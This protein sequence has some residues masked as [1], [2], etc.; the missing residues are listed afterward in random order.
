M[1]VF[2]VYH[3][4]LVKKWKELVIKQLARLE[5]S[6]LLARA[7]KLY[8]VVIDQNNNKQEFLDIISK[9][10]NIEAEFFK[11]N[12]CEFQSITKVWQLGQYNDCK[13]LYFHTKGVFN[14]YV[15]V[16]GTEISDLKVKTVRDWRMLMEYFCID[17]WDENL[18]RLDS[19]D[20]VGTNCTRNWWWGNFWWARSSYL[21][22]LEL[23]TKSSRWGYEAWVNERGLAS[24]YEHH[25]I[26]FIFYF[27]DYP[28]K[29]YKDDQYKVLKGSTITVHEA[30]YGASEIQIDEGYAK[31]APVFKDVTDI[32]RANLAKNN[33]LYIDIEVNNDTMQ[34]DP[35]FMTKKSIFIEYSFDKEPDKKYSLHSIE[36]TPI[37][38]PWFNL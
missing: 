15:S 23:P 14:D 20:M 11:D 2:I 16:D 36:H 35:I 33:N 5:S 18:Q 10:P 30:K 22:T 6:G 32:I 4:F 31:S 27:T 3:C 21:K 26:S 28:E 29:F 7:D 37:K 38:F 12:D 1:K 9:Y 34:G 13:V 25:H 24:I 19:V 8:C 17:K